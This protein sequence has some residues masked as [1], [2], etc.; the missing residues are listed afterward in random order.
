MRILH[1]HFLLIALIASLGSC[2]CN[3]S[4][5]DVAPLAAG[6]SE[7]AKAN[8]KPESKDGIPTDRL[9]V[10]L[11]EHY[12][13]LGF[14]E[15]YDYEK[16]AEAFRKVHE[17][18]PQWIPGSINLAIALMNQSGPRK[19][20]LGLAVEGDP[21]HEALVLLD[22]VVARDSKNPYARFCRGLMFEMLDQLEK[23]HADFQ[24]VVEQDPSDAHAWYERGSTV[25]RDVKAGPQANEQI[26]DF[27]RAL[28]CNPYLSAAY[29]KLFRALRLSD[30]PEGAKRQL[31]LWKQLE[32]G[33]G[34]IRFGDEMER[35]YGAEGRYAQV[36]NPLVDQKAPSSPIRLPRFDLPAPVKVQLAGG[37]RW[38]SSS[39]FTGRLA[40]LGRARA[41]FGAPI[42]AF[43]A[44]GDG[45]TDLFLPAAVVGPRG[46]RDALLLNRGEGSFEDATLLW[47]LPD[48]RASLGAAAGDFDGDGRV[49]LFLTGIGDN[50]LY[51]NEKPTGFKDVT[52][53]AGVTDPPA[54]SLTARWLDLDQDGDLDLYVVNYT[55]LD[56]LD[57]AFTDKAPSGIANSVYR[58]DGQ[59]SPIPGTPPSEWAPRAMARDPEKAPSG[60][61]IKMTPWTGSDAILGGAALHTGLA[62]LD[63]DDDRDLDLVLA[64]EGAAPQAVLNDRIGRFHS[65]TIQGPEPRV[66]DAGLLVI[67]LDNDGHA[68]LAASDSAGKLTVWKNV[69]LRKGADVTITFERWPTNAVRWRGA[70]TADVDLDGR[71]DLLGLTSSDRLPMPGWARNDGRRLSSMSLPIVPDDSVAAA[72]PAMAWADLAGD[73]LPDLVLIK[74]GEIPRLAR[75]L[76][77]GHHWLALRLSGRW[78]TWGRLRT[79][80]HGIGARVW[81]QGPN[82]NIPFD[83]I[84]PEAGLAQSC[85][86]ITLGLGQQDSSAVVRLRWPDGV[87][88]CELNVPADQTLAL[89]ETTHRVSTCPILF[90]W[91]GR[92]FQ[93]VG[94]LLDGGGL[95]YDLGPG[96]WNEPDR[97]ESV[98]IEE[99][100][101]RPV[102]GVYRLVITEPMDEVAYLDHL[103]LDVVDRPPGISTALDERFVAEGTRPTGRILAWKRSI[104]PVRATDLAGNDLTETLRSWDRRT[105]DGFKRLEGW[106]GYAQEH[107]I[108]LDF[109]DRLSGSSGT[110]R[111][112]LFL[113]GWVE[114]PF[115]QTNYAAA[116]AGVPLR[117]PVLERQQED[118]SWALIDAHPGCPS[119]LPKLTTLD[120]TGKLNGPQCVVR[121]RTNL[122][123]YWDQAFLAVLEPDPGIRVTSLPVAR[124]VLGY[125]GYT[126][127]SSPD[128]RMPMLYDYD[129]VVPMPL[130]RMSGDLT[131]YGEVAPLLQADDDQLCLVGPGD[132]VRVD[133]DGKSVPSLAPGWTRGYV[134]RSVGYCKDADLFTATGDTV[135]PLPWRGMKSYPFGREGQRPEDAA[136][137][138]YLREY[139]TRPAGNARGEVNGTPEAE[140]PKA[141]PH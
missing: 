134:L 118:G 119:G 124:A 22:D 23:A 78:A 53:A 73:A 38:V 120:V 18:A 30:D 7:Q 98:A 48:D 136:Y 63:L 1:H 122:E 62:L 138:A 46:V 135:G 10:I 93:C 64:A 35:S 115:S 132:E 32:G 82:L 72:I 33:P 61:S 91:D 140:I 26:A 14:I 125:R 40:V 79:N 111:L 92:R 17:L 76:G 99:S 110:D 51:R 6:H 20:D 86:P 85:V 50:R 101:L 116:T 45:R 47:R 57:Q 108:V 60:L 109:G 94:D 9:D 141:R 131:R 127:E 97:D 107:G 123:C 52:K 41:R 5:P 16:A 105:A 117:L 102:K 56:H 2:G 11:K 126:L 84:T 104:E 3:S 49:D 133:F 87:S 128:G 106:N 88:Q 24:V 29:F 90:V 80:P 114:F 77:N 103:T 27:R 28:E 65:A 68:D 44:D 75:N 37:E 69:T 66:A 67:D 96:V 121:L 83:A 81:L 8:P 74:D 12:R 4:K 19:D 34:A 39:D 89:V 55:G 58:N 100:Q 36:I 42:V 21:Q 15:R 25:G 31:A 43:D 130:T 137:R 112:S 95:G 71:P 129:T 54:L 113:A 59:P 139:Q 13:G 70:M